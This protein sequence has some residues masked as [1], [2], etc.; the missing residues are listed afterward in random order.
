MGSRR[1][2]TFRDIPRHLLVRGERA[3]RRR[4]H[5]IHGR[6]GGATGQWAGVSGV[7]CSWPGQANDSVD[8]FQEPFSQ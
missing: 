1:S 7:M 4:Q 8:F 5:T 6:R 2:E 3:D